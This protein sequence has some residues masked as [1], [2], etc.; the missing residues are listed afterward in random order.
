MSHCFLSFSC[1]SIFSQFAIKIDQTEAFL[2]NP[3]EFE[4]TEALQ[5]LLQ[6]HD[7]H[8]KGKKWLYVLV[9]DNI[10]LLLSLFPKKKK[11]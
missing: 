5:S 9:I 8:A 4:S 3:H 2:Q 11:R 1:L 6:L 7:R 10:C